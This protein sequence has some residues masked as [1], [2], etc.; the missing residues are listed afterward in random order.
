MGFQNTLDV[1]HI[2]GPTICKFQ[3]YVAIETSIKPRVIIKNGFVSGMCTR[4]SVRVSNGL[5]MLG[6]SYFVLVLSNEIVGFWKEFLSALR[7]LTFV[8]RHQSGIPGHTLITWEAVSGWIFNA[9]T[10][11]FKGHHN[12]ILLQPMEISGIEKRDTFPML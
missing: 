4:S 5:G 11:Q 6:Y 12:S 2:C 9:I 1:F 7:R 10:V 3:N 8:F